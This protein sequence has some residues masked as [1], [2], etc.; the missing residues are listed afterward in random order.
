MNSAADIWEKVKSM[1]A[2]ELTAV[3]MDTW[4]GDVEAVALGGRGYVVMDSS[5][6]WWTNDITYST[7]PYLLS[8]DNIDWQP[9][10][11]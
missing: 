3:T 10:E 5:G 2:G 7:M 4:F 8:L 1:M 9:Y 6:T 11:G